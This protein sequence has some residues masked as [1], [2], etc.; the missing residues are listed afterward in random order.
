MNVCSVKKT[1]WVETYFIKSYRFIFYTVEL[2]DKIFEN[3]DLPI[4]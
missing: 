2:A 3:A 4:N 1:G